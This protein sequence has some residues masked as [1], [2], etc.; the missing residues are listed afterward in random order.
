L[1]LRSGIRGPWLGCSRFPRCRG[2]GKWTDLDEKKQAQL[3]AALEAHERA[4][5]IPIIRTLDGRALTDAKGKPLPDAPT[6]EQL[7][8]QAHPAQEVADAE[9][10]AVG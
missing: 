3:E 7:V 6:V 2:R 1:N 4:H 9:L 10:E 8:A 5:P